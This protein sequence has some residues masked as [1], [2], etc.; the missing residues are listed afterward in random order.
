LPWAP[1]KVYARVPFARV[2]EKGIYDYATGHWET[3]IRFKNYTNNTWIEGVPS[4]TL[5]IPEGKYNVL[6]GRSYF[7]LAREGL[8]EQKSQNGGIS[9]PAPRSVNSPYHLY[10][11][12]VNT[13][14]PSHEES[15]FDGIDISLPAIADY[16]PTDQRRPGR[17]VSSN[18]VL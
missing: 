14:S 3:P 2:S 9:I 17:N 15:F 11:S 1:L 18:S 13:A 7:T 5:T 6:L 16:A 12:R 8:A 10:A 4:I